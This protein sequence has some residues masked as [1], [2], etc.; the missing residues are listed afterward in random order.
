MKISLARPILALALL[1]GGC[2]TRPK[3]PTTHIF[4]PPAPDEPRIQYL[5]SFGSEV[6]LGGRSQFAKFVLGGQEIHRPIVKPYG[7]TATPGKLYICDTQVAAVEVV[8]LAQR[9]L[10]YFKPP[11]EGALA[12]PINIAVD[13]AGNIRYANQTVVF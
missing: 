8:D 7:I 9:T 10:R 5:T 12:V 6:D 11:G 13:K 4:F 3:A 2:A 1:A